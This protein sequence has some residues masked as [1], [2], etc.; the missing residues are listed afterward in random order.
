MSVQAPCYRGENQ[1]RGTGRGGQ[2]RG[3]VNKKGNEGN[4]GDGNGDETR[5]VCRNR[6]GDGNGDEYGDENE[7]EEREGRKLGNPS[8]RY[9][10]GRVGDGME[11]GATA[12]GN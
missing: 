7:E 12:T 2:G 4:S 1:V 11:G 5:N 6:R 10:K 9:D 3:D 8:Q